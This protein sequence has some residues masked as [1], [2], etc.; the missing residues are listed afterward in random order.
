MGNIISSM[1]FLLYEWKWEAHN[2][3]VDPHYVQSS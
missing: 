1:Q 3:R 2:P